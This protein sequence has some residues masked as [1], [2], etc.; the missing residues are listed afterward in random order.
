LRAYANGAPLNVDDYP[1]VIFSA[2]RQAYAPRAQPYRL[3]LD[4]LAKAGS[5][6]RFLVAGPRQGED[7]HLAENLVAYVAAR[8]LYLQGLAKEV[9]GKLHPAVELY[10]RSSAASVFFTPAYARCVSI[11]QAMSRA[12][13]EGARAL[14][15]AL[16][17]AQPAQPLGRK[18]LGP[19]L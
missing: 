3:L 11:I 14:F 6:P 16:E 9:E 8:D 7:G 2:G 13:L 12:D 17:A 4:F 18:L 5:S 15:R 19:K 1:R 10:L